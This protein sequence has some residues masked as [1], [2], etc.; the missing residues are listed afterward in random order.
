MPYKSVVPFGLYL[1]VSFASVTDS[2]ALDDYRPPLTPI[3]PYSAT[4]SQQKE[5]VQF[6]QR[7]RVPNGDEDED[8]WF[9]EHDSDNLNRHLDT[10][11]QNDAQLQTSIKEQ[12]KINKLKKFFRKVTFIIGKNQAYI[13]DFYEGG[14]ECLVGKEASNQLAQ[15]IAELRE[16]ETLIQEECRDV[17]G[18][19]GR[20]YCQTQLTD[21]Q[22]QISSFEKFQNEFENQCN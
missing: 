14:Y 3:T 19:N 8:S 15:D 6:P 9:P 4:E 2:S 22:S 12:R 18:A 7:P 5:R 16:Q 13:N 11:K 20:R 21:I 17:R 10:I 1:F